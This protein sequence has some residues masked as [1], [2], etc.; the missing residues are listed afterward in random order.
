MRRLFTLILLLL[1][2][3]TSCNVADTHDTVKEDN[4][5]EALP[6]DKEVSE[7]E[8]TF[9]ASFFDGTT[10]DEIESTAIENGVN[11]VVF[12]DDESVTYIMDKDNHKE[13]LSDIKSS[14]DETIQEILNDEELYQS[15]IDITY[16]D[17]LSE[18]KIMCDK[19]KYSEFD[20]FV[21]LAL[22]LQSAFYQ[23]L[24]GIES[25]SINTV[26]YFI[27]Q[28][29]GDVFHTADSSKISE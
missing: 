17:E 13:M 26:V 14:I 11:D 3:I 19:E 28:S 23:T 24:N 20:S 4:A 22:Y 27:D 21:A 16:N 5:G 29:T 18:F 6:S 9:P 7:V 8:V 1:L 2:V 10:Q 25:D 15:F 12:N